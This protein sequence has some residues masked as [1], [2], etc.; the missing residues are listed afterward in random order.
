MPDA[1]IHPD[2]PAP[3]NIHACVSTR[4]AP[5]VSLPPYGPCNLGLRSGDDQAAVRRNRELLAEALALPA[6]PSWLR[7]VHGSGVLRL[8]APVAD[9]PEADAAVASAV[10]VVLAIL[11]ADCLPVLFCAVDGSEIGAAHAGWRGLA[12]GVLENTVA[13]MRAPPDRLLAWLGPCIGPPSF[14]VGEEVCAAFIDHDPQAA[15]AFAP[16]RSGHAFC[17]LA[18]LARQRLAGCGVT[19]VGGGGF[20]TRTD[21]RLH[22]YR[23]DGLSSGRLAALVWR[24]VAV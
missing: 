4:L 5:G 9:E 13:A 20:D 7:Q 2:W 14:E 16:G 19:A 15:A 3:E 1:W 17:D 6:P 21:P 12:A 8:D 18:A 23:R 24:S 10:G 11:V 22:S